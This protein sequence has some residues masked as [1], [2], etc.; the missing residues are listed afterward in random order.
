MDGE[1]LGAKDSVRKLSH[2]RR[3]AI[4]RSEARRIVATLIALAGS[5]EDFKIDSFIDYFQERGSFT[6]KQLGLLLWRLEKHRIPHLGCKFK[7]ALRRH[8]EQ[9]Q[10]KGM[11]DWQ[12]T[13]LWPYLSLAQRDLCRALRT[14]E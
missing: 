11:A 8:R 9:A 6:P 13:K 5:D 1:V 7:I 14:E 2:D 4:A 12:I 10:L 3:E